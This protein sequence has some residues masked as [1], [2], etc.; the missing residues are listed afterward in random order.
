VLPGCGILLGT[1]GPEG[2]DALISVRVAGEIPDEELSLEIAGAAWT[3]DGP[4]VAALSAGLPP[5]VRLI[6]ADGCEV[7]VEFEAVQGHAYAITFGASGD[8][9]VE[10]GVGDGDVGL[11]FERRDPTGCP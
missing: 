7:H 8:A 5:R 3:V 4:G 10:E 11:P 2:S 9:T 6:S 1:P